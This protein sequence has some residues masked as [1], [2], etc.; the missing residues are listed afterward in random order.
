MPLEA[1][2]AQKMSIYVKNQLFNKK[3]VI[4]SFLVLAVC[5]NYPLGGVFH[6]FG[7]FL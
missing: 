1:S 4:Y 3:R 7:R 6:I 5:K 2:G